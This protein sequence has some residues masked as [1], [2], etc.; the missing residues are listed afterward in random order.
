MRQQFLIHQ[1]DD[2]VGVAVQDLAPGPG[3][4]GRFQT[5]GE[6]LEVEVLD[7]VPLGHKVALRDIPEGELVIEYG[8]AIGLATSDIRTGQHVHVHNVKG[9]RWA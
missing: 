2:M 7:P 5:S 3:V 1:A 6:E 8:I 9:R 4:T